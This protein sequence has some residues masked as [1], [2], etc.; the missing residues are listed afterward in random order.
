[1]YWPFA[2]LLSLLAFSFFML[3]RVK[4]V[5]NV[6]IQYIDDVYD[7]ICREAKKGTYVD[8]RRAYDALLDFHGMVWRFWR[9]DVEEMIADREAY[10]AVYG[11]SP[12]VALRRSEGV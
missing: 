10:N 11:R 1:M 9:W 8:S 12:A 4:W 6:R 2:I 3:A 5:H 7:F